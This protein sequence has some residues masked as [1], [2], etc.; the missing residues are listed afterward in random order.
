MSEVGATVPVNG[1]A[2][3]VCMFGGHQW[4]VRR[5]SFP[6][7]DRSWS[8]TRYYSSRIKPG[9]SVDVVSCLFSFPASTSCALY[10]ES[11]GHAGIVKANS[12][13][14]RTGRCASMEF[15]LADCASNNDC[16]PFRNRP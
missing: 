8:N 3:V 12:T 16:H 15:T 7:V 11:N 13:G 9:L 5:C 10:Y 2:F 14:G 6:G 4:R 1:D